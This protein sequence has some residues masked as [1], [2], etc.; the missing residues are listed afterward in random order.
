MSHLD[1]FINIM[2]YFADGLPNAPADPWTC[3]WYTRP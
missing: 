3:Q 2:E 1:T